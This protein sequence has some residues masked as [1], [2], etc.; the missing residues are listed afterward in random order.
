MDKIVRGEDIRKHLEAIYRYSLTND[1]EPGLMN[2]YLL[3]HAWDSLEEIG[4]NYY[5]EG[6]DLDNIQDR[7]QEYSRAWIAHFVQGNE[8]ELFPQKVQP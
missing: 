6:V 2:F 5:I 3:F 4:C 7:V 8:N 1:Y